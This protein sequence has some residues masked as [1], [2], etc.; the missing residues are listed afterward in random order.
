MNSRALVL[1][2][3]V[4]VLLC[5]LALHGSKSIPPA[6]HNF[7]S[8]DVQQLEWSFRI[9][10]ASDQRFERARIASHLARVEALLRAADVSALGPLQV[11]V[12]ARNL[13]ALREYRQRGRFPHNHVVAD[14][15]T[16]VF[17]DEHGTHCAVGYLI[18]RS[19]HEALAQ[20]IANTRNLARIADLADD[21][22]LLCWLD[23]ACVLRLEYLWV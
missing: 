3:G 2:M 6:L 12:R 19:G 18:A 8:D 20:R 15:R 10:T 23:A 5:G 4:A 21:P 9:A 1:S 22:E 7:A 17:V 14:R 13:D 11:A 16:P